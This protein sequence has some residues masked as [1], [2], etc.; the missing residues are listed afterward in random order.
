MPSHPRSLTLT[1]SPCSVST[2]TYTH[3]HTRALSLLVDLPNDT[4]YDSILVI[5]SGDFLYSLC[6]LRP[7]SATPYP[8]YCKG[9]TGDS[10]TTTDKKTN[11]MSLTI[12]AKVRINA[13]VFEIN[14]TTAI[15]RVN[16]I[17]PLISIVTQNS[18]V[19]ILS[20]GSS[21]TSQMQHATPMRRAHSGAM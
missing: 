10:N 4:T 19:Y 17:M 21:C 7:S 1:H 3:P 15:L 14:S 16:A 11:N 2:L 20:H 18:V 13:E 5:F 9:V 6:K 12:P 8:A